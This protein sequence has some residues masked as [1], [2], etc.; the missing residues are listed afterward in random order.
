MIILWKQDTL[1]VLLK[2]QALAWLP[3]YLAGCWNAL[4]AYQDSAL[5]PLAALQTFLFSTAI[6]TLAYGVLV[7]IAFAPKLSYRLRVGLLL[8]MYYALSV[9]LFRLSALSGDARLMLF[10]FLLFSSIFLEPPYP[11]LAVGLAM[12]N[13][14]VMGWLY[15]S[16]FIQLAEPDRYNAYDPTAWV[17]GGIV[18]FI[19]GI[20]TV[21]VTQFL[22][23]SFA[24]TVS[25][26]QMVSQF[27]AL[28]SAVNQLIVR[29]QSSTQLLQETCQ[30]LRA[31]GYAQI[32]LGTC[33]ADGPGWQEVVFQDS[34]SEALM[35]LAE[36]AVTLG[37]PVE[38]FPRLALP[39]RREQ[40][41]LGA[42]V[43]RL[44]TAENQERQI[45]NEIADDLSYALD[46][47]QITFQREFLTQTAEEL[48][49][50]R[51]ESVIWQIALTATRHLLF[52][53]RAAIYE[54]DPASDRLS[55]PHFSGLSPDYVQKIN[56]TFRSIPGG[57]LLSQPQ[58][59]LIEDVM[60]SPLTQNIRS[61]LQNEN[62]RAY[63]VFPL[64]A[65]KKLIGAFVAYY[66]YPH[67]FSTAD[68]SVG[69][70]LAH[71]LVASLQN[72]RLFAETRA[73]SNEQAAL[74]VA[75]QETSLRLDDF[76]ALLG[77]LCQQ[78][79][80]VLQVTSAYILEVNQAAGTL[81]VLSE[82]WTSEAA[83]TELRSDL[84][85]IY[86]ILDFPLALAAARQGVTLVLDDDDPRLTPLEHAEFVEYGVRTK[87]LLPL[88]WQ[89][90]LVGIAELWESRQRRVFR[91]H[92]I[93]LAQALASHA[94]GALRT[95][96]L[97]NEIQTR[98]AYFRALTEHA[99]E[100]VA[101]LDQ[102]GEFKYIS[103][104]QRQM[105]G[106]EDSLISLSA[107]M[108]KIH[109]EDL[110]LVRKIFLQVRR[111]PNTPITLTCR[112]Q[113]RQNEWRILESTLNNLIHNSAI[114]G[115]V[116]NFRDVTLQKQAEEQLRQAYDETLAGWARALELRDKDTEGHTRRV[117]EL[118][119]H[120]ARAMGVEEEQL[121]QIRRGALLHDI[122]K[123]AIPDA[124]LHKTD[125]L[126]IQEWEI[127]RRHPQYAYDML[128]DI[129]YLRSSL[130]IP[131][132]HHEKWDGSGYPR[133]L[134]G[135]EIPLAARIFAIADVWDALTSNRPYR[136]SWDKERTLE[137]IK[138]QAGKQFD[139]AIV[140]LFIRIV[141]KEDIH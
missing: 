133:G 19:I 4:H 39:L 57:Q 131:Y 59:L 31:N 56:Q 94:A 105:L 9:A 92:E 136:P 17:S 126:T 36:Q 23:R 121:V 45:C 118:T 128:K 28:G 62:I 122:G 129:A 91:Q 107:L 119:L 40:R 58:P 52:A 55:C 104:V 22:L 65:R 70:T 124:I 43:L 33:P 2:I 141:S 113:N 16:G 114:Q 18:L 61:M 138:E 76:T 66:R 12:L 120:L 71:F 140:E 115:I 74:F 88:I 100:G 38:A 46:N 132:C 14:G 108:Q 112:I 102:M 89:G 134:K 86:P 64:F 15:I 42:L 54:Y 81:Q 117:T 44:Q 87:L 50:E 72:A 47:L 68:V 26:Q 13:F 21:T 8:G 25:R 67:Y 53:E 73:K 101:V 109:P 6:Y 37:Q 32:W 84:H 130:E 3:G 98:E 34:E 10:V 99:S 116:V 51:D 95:A 1:N 83:S 30:T 29:A 63:A 5:E 137:Y 80:D 75:A 48:L 79:A 69:Q 123:V 103:P 97:F 93:H 139:P 96:K 135:E 27:L 20:T 49:G 82:Y 60:L 85:R 90:E 125:A 78:M 127:M 11:Y 106:Y 111:S 77:L 41:T 7:F 110:S 35:G 24:E